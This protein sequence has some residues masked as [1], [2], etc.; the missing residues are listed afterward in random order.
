MNARLLSLVFVVALPIVMG[1]DSWKSPDPASSDDVRLTG[2]WG[3]AQAR[4]AERLAAAP[5]DK[6]EFILDDVSLRQH[7]KFAEYSG[8]ISGRW[9]GAAAFL[10][11][12]FPKPFA[13]LPTILADIPNYQKSDGHFGV[14]Q[15]LPEI[16]RTRDMPILWGNG[17]LLIGLVEVYERTGDHK[18][19]DAAKKLGDYFISTDPVYDKAENLKSVGGTYSDGFA[20][21]YFSCIEG[22]VGLGRVTKDERYLDAAKRIAELAFSVD[23]FA[24]LHSHGRLCAVRGFADLYAATGDAHWRD[25]A[26][27]DWTIFRERYRLPTGGIKEVLNAKCNADEGCSVCDWLRLNL[28]LWRLTGRPRYLNEAERC[29]KG[30]FIFQQFPNGGAGHRLF[31]QINGQPVAFKGPRE[32]AWWCCSEHWARAMVD[33]TRLAVTAGQQGP[34]I[35]LAIDCQSAVAG[36]GGKWNV[37]VRETED[38]LR[39][40]VKSPTATKAAVRI[41]RPEW[42]QDDVRIEKPAG[43]SLRDDKAAWLVEGVWDGSQA[44]VVHLPTTLRSESAPGDAGVLLRGHDLLVAHRVPANAWLME[45]LAVARPV[46]LWAAALPAKDGRIVVPASDAEDADPNNPEQ[47]KLLELAPL[48]ALTGQPHDAAW[49]SFRLQPAS[50]EQITALTA[51]I[52]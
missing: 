4:N 35:N 43:L 49:F 11:P 27:R 47:W 18:A 16:S 21:C 6:P 51:K 2:I 42:T 22:L 9:I 23:D 10:A 40:V 5:L 26:E 13:A 41:H 15:H 44:L 1:A 28:S 33:V 45:R 37:S 50:V 3:A 31:Y 39:I 12:Q 34:C 52:R 38:G 25:A 17:R 29:L 46:V 19:L 7:R 20:T 24:G 14:E 8:D 48:R 30:H 32:E 36:P